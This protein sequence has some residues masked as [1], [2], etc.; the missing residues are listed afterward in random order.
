[1]TMH[2]DDARQDEYWSTYWA[3][4]RDE[5][6]AKRRQ[7]Y[8]RDSTYRRKVNAAARR[9]HRETYT[10]VPPEER[11]PRRGP[12][13]VVREINGKTVRL[14]PAGIL[15]RAIGRNYQTIKNWRRAGVLPAACHQAENGFAL[16]TLPQIQAV[17]GA[18]AECGI[19]RGTR[20]ADLRALRIAVRRRWDALGKLGLGT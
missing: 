17:I 13:S 7:R 19:G 14:Y 18:M 16:Y 12:G 20:A 6:L 11:L 9:R 4:H 10:P 2:A 1:M 8:R 15:A 3:T 5:I